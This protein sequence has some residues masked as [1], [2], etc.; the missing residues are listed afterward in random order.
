MVLGGIPY[1]L[2]LLDPR[3]NVPDNID[4]L[5]FEVP[6]SGQKSFKSVQIKQ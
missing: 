6:L 5:F 1:Y 4:S 2:S 3:K